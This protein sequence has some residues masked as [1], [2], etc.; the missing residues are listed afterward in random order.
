MR[1]RRR[2]YIWIGVLVFGLALVIFLLGP[3]LFADIAFPLPDKYRA[4]I[5]KYSKECGIY[6]P[7]FLAA[8]IYTE[9][10]F[11][12]SAHSSAGAK[13]LTQ[14]IDS[15]GRSIASRLGVT[16]YSPNDLITDPDLSIRFGAYYICEAIKRYG[17]DKKLGLIAYNGGGAAVNAYRAG[18]PVRGTVAYANKIISIEQAYQQIYGNWG[19]QAQSATTTSPAQFNV[20]P[21]KELN[22][23]LTIPL[24][25][26]WQSLL[27]NRP[28][29]TPAPSGDILNNFLSP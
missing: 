20:Q 25:T 21:K 8:L 9:S 27:I 12:E 2:L 24:G 13:G 19:D 23:L 14:V 1:A 29:Q 22:N 4:S 11:K 7:N 18:N 17:N 16:N 15:T 3:V 10:H 28:V 5:A 6:S 26:F